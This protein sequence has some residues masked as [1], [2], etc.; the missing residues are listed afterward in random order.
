MATHSSIL[1]WRIPW[2]EE[3]DGLQPTGSQR[4]RCYWVTNTFTFFLDYSSSNYVH[5]LGRVYRSFEEDILTINSSVF[6]LETH[7]AFF[8]CQLH[9]HMLLSEMIFITKI[10]IICY[11]PMQ[12]IQDFFPETFY[13]SV[14]TSSQKLR[15]IFYFQLVPPWNWVHIIIR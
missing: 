7:C 1:A 5:C 8:P 12:I 9:M 13:S 11:Q 10:I 2:T 15:K 3:A 14:G 4:V 6:V